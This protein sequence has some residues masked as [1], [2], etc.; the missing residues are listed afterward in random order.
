MDLFDS[1]DIIKCFLLDPLS[2]GY[3]MNPPQAWTPKPGGRCGT[4][5]TVSSK[6]AALLCLPHI[7]K[8][9]SIFPDA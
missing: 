8:T 5:S 2:L 7:G 6:R 1:I 9:H 4:A 3:R